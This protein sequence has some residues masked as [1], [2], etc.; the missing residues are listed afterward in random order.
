MSVL[1]VLKLSIYEIGGSVGCASNWR[2]EG[3]RFNPHQQY[4]L[5]KI[6]HEIFST[7]ILSLLLVKEGPLSVSGNRMCTSIC[8]GKKHAASG[9]MQ[10]FLSLPTVCSGPILM[11]II[12]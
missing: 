2:Q 4:S 9:G 1:T 10:D 11:N 5:F 6:D 8:T 12:A 7:V 3:R